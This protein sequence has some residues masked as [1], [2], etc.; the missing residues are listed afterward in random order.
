[1]YAKILL[2]GGMDLKDI[3][4]KPCDRMGG[5]LSKTLLALN[6]LQRCC[7]GGI[8]LYSAFLFSP[9]LLFGLR[10]QGVELLQAS[11]GQTYLAS[12]ANHRFCAD[13]NGEY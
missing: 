7:I 5:T 13:M 1:L 2:M 12:Q 11:A 6:R 4:I 9:T 3:C 10:G 8:L